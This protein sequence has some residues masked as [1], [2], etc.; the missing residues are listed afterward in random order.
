M[1]SKYSSAFPLRAHAAPRDV[2]ECRD[3][4][5]LSHRRLVA[6]KRPHASAPARVPALARAVN[7]PFHIHASL[8]PTATSR[9]AKAVTSPR[10][11]NPPSRSAGGPP[12]SASRAALLLTYRNRPGCEFRGVPAP[13]LP[14][15]SRRIL[16]CR[17]LSPLSRR[18]LVAVKRPH[19]S[20]PACVPALARAVNAPFHIHASRTP[21]ATSRLVKAVTSP[22]T[23]KQSVAPSVVYPHP[24]S[25]RVQSVANKSFPSTRQTHDQTHPSPAHPHPH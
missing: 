20:A 8:N 5:P 21:T 23:P 14:A 4:S 12:A 2:L 19:A 13:C 10:T 17:D 11:P 15:A 1:R 16:E 6:V 7:A 24:C 3:S 9:L 25:V 18:R 22:R